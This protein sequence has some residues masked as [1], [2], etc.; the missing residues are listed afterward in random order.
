[1]SNGLLM[2]GDT[3]VGCGK[4]LRLCL[5]YSTPVKVGISLQ[6]TLEQHTTL[7]SNLLT[8]RCFFHEVGAWIPKRKA[9][10]LIGNRV[11]IERFA[12]ERSRNIS[13]CQFNSDSLISVR[14]RGLR[15]GYKNT[16][17]CTILRVIAIVHT[18]AHAARLIVFCGCR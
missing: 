9:T 7:Y 10:I 18:S 2:P 11:A 8:S 14:Y 5:L 17:F 3:C 13:F 12:Q 6:H 1:M 4:L 16:S 15:H